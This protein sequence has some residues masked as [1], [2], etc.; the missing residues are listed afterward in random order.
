[1]INAKLIDDLAQRPCGRNSDPRV[2]VG[3]CGGQ[4][5]H[6]IAGL[7]VHPAECVRR[8]VIPGLE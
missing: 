1:M 2:G 4:R 6:G 5:R 3:E 7:L 8:A